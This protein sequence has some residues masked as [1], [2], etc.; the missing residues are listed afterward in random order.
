MKKKVTRTIYQPHDE[1]V[2]RVKADTA[3]KIIQG[4]RQQSA[5]SQTIAANATMEVIK[6]QA[7]QDATH[8]TEI[9]DDLAKQFNY[10]EA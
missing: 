7:E 2:L 4:L 3:R 1:V 10:P 5:Y 6:H 9:A 8:F